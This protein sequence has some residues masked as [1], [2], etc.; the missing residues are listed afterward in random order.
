MGCAEESSNGGHADMRFR[1]G[2]KR[3]N[4]SGKGSGKNRGPSMGWVIEPLTV[5]ESLSDDSTRLQFTAKR[6]IHHICSRFAMNLSFNILERIL[7]FFN[8]S[9]RQKLG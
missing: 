4:I 5:D 8:S 7:R 3:R 6:R 9:L 1:S 2:E